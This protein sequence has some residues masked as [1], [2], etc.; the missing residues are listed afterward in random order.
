MAWDP[1]AA[2]G[3]EAMV[4]IGELPLRIIAGAVDIIAAAGL[5]GRMYLVS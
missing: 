4:G 1:E 2:L 5:Y 3:T